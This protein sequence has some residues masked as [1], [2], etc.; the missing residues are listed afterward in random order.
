MK[1]YFLLSTMLLLAVAACKKE[2]IT[3]GGDPVPEPGAT[4]LLE[5]TV[6]TE[7]FAWKTNSSVGLYSAMDAVRIINKECKIVGWADTTPVY[8]EDGNNTNDYTPSEYEGKAVAR[9][10][11]PALDLVQGEN[12]FMVYTPY[13]SELT[14]TAGTIYGLSIGDNQRQTAPNVAADCFAIGY[15]TG[16]PGVDEAFKF[17]LNPV[18]ALAQ[19]KIGSSEFTGYSPQKVSIYDDSGTTIAGGFNINVETNEIQPVGDPLTSVAVTVQNPVALASGQTQNLYLNILPADFSTKPVWVVVE[20]VDA[21][22]GKVT[23]PTQQTGLKFTAGQTTV[24]DLSDLKAE[25]ND[26]GAW[27]CPDD[28]RL[29]P[30]LG[31]AYGQANT[32]FIQCKSATYNGATL[33]ANPDIPD[34]VVIDYRIR[35]NFASITDD[36]K[37]EGVTFEW[38][39]RSNGTM[40]TAT[41]GKGSSTDYSSSKVVI[42]DATFTFTVDEANHQVKVKNEGAFAGSPILVMK[43]K[44]KILWAWSF[45]NIAADGTSIEPIQV[46]NYKFAP[47]DIGQPT[48]NIDTWIAN[49]NGSNPDPIFRMTHFYQYGRPYPIFWTNYWSMDGIAGKSG[50]MPTVLGPKTLEEAISNPALIG[51]PGDVTAQ[52]DWCSTTYDGL[53]GAT[54]IK[55][56]GAKTIYDPC[57]KG[58]RVASMPALQTLADLGGSASFSEESGKIMTT[59]N[60]L[61]LITHGY[62]TS[63]DPTGRTQYRPENIGLGLNANTSACKE[64]ILWGN[65]SG[66]SQGQCLYYTSNNSSLSEEDRHIIEINSRNRACAA[67]VRCI[68]DDDNR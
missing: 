37:P 42:S 34:E 46:G 47:M 59:V 10:N 19:V 43:K 9:F 22:G 62:Q 60:G 64:A 58:W 33:K 4:Y 52:A 50:N 53:W 39:T 2:E 56:E 55:E 28:S 5:G 3:E 38:F 11:T 8:D 67:A 15:A 66:T 23:I 29:L 45:W 48:T 61:T 12:K 20:L 51:Y 18:T 21:A 16:T 17:E 35:G 36:M 30:G 68:K 7:G 6:N 57:P 54:D 41:Q 1:R 63:K 44:G 49:K 32:F 25:D 24:I 26:A 13:N 40:Y 31:Y 65:V 14:Y 27:Y